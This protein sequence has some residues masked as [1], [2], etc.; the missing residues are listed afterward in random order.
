ME[1]ELSSATR[2]VIL[3]TFIVYSIALLVVGFYS[4]RRMDKTALDK[5]V[6]EFYTGGRG[7][8]SLVIALMIAAGLCSCLL[9]TS[10]CV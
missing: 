5:F 9:Y 7:M 10:R 2:T 4:K 8:G 6:E 1:W 3:I